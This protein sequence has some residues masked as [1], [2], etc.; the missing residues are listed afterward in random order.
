M[1]EGL[2]RHAP[3]I[4]IIIAAVFILSM[5]IR[6]ITSIFTKTEYVGIIDG[7]K[8]TP[9]RY[10]EILERSF[11]RFAQENPEK[12]IG[13]Q[14]AKELND[15]TWDQLV[16][17]ILFD[18]EVKKRD[19]EIDTDDIVQKMKN[20]S[21]DIKAIEQLQTDGKFDYAK[22]EKV[23]LENPEFS[24]WIESRIRGTL[25][26]EKL[27]ADVKAEV[28][29]TT[30]EI[31]QDYIDDNDKADA[32]IIFFNPKNIEVEITDEDLQKYYK[33]HKEEYKKG[34][35]RKL[36]FVKI[37]LDPSEEDKQN[38]K[39]EADSIYEKIVNGL[40]FADAAKEY[41][42]GPS[43][44]KGGDLGF[45]TKERMVEAFSNKA[46]KMNIG[47]ISKPVLTRF[48][49]H[50]IKVTDN[51]INEKGIKE[52]KAS[53]VLIKAEPSEKTKANF[54]IKA[55][56]LYEQ[57]TEL[58]IDKA[59]EA[60][61]YEVKETEEFYEDARYIPGIGPNE[62]IVKFA[63]SKKVGDVHKPI[64]VRGGNYIITEISYSV[65]EHYLDFE[66]KKDHVSRELTKELRLE[67]V[68]KQANEFVK[69]FEEINYFAEAKKSD[70]Q[71]VTS[72]DITINKTLKEIG[73][74]ET[75]NKAIVSKNENEYTDLI[76]DKGG[77]Y[78]AYVTKR[79]KPD[80]DK[81]EKKKSSLL[82]KKQETEENKHLNN[83]FK[84][85]KDNA[86][87]VDN[88]KNFYNL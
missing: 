38:A 55:N 72:K 75:L 30:E 11:A 57:A 18:K 58:S 67:E 21:D 22:Y 29:I 70:L 8:I 51:K 74:S 60:L 45:F 37:N 81:F 33:D 73:K 65:G 86:E 84:D 77:A 59:A 69:N 19:L 62:D 71:I 12:E 83:W 6:G 32:K 48:G 1:F 88:R 36:K 34:P 56:D 24:N 64:T 53:H 68:N 66:T 46:F 85:L 61:A 47:D 42:Q 25:P 17:Q 63:F 15:Q 82:K 3:W 54:E 50:L 44:S 31:K 7:E 87:I 41:S 43:A 79:V 13:D 5:A 40:D 9:K 78:I 35:G 80:M 49:W 28:Q 14:Q 52:V 2:R 20:P 4:V 26:Y 10:S 76:H 16:Q 39:K 23:L 27:Y